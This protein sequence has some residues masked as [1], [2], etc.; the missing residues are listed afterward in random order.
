[1]SAPDPSDLDTE[2][3]SNLDYDLWK[4]I[5]AFA[6][7]HKRLLYPLAFAAVA[8]SIVES[9]YPIATKMAVDI[10]QSDQPI[11][12]LW[13][14]GLFFFGLSIVLSVLVWLFIVCAGSISHHI[15]FDIKRACFKRLQELEFSFYDAQ[16]TGW[17]IS[18]LT[19]DCDRLSRILAWGFLDIVWGLC[20]VGAMAV[21]M[22]LLNA[23]LALIVLSTILPLIVISKFF[24][25]RM[26]VASRQIRKH[27]ARI[28]ASYNEG[29]AGVKTTKTLGRESSN[30]EE[31]QGVSTDMYG[32][33]IRRALLGAV[34]MPLVMAIGA[35]G[36]GLALWYGGSSVI[37]QTLSLGTLIAL[38]SFAGQFFFPINQIAMV[39]AEL[40]GAQAAGERVMSLLATRPNINDS[41]QVEERLA[42]YA[43]P[44]DP[45][46]APDGYDD[47]IERIEFVDIGFSYN[48]QEIILS[49]F[50]LA[51]QRGQTI[52]LVGPSGGGKSTIVSLLSR[53]YEPTRGS[54][55]INGI[56]YRE[57]SLSWLQSQLGIVLQ[58]PHLFN[59]TVREN[60]RYG[61]LE[62]TD[63]ELEEVA[64]WVNAHEFVSKLKNGYDTTIGEGGAR[65]STGERQL[66]SFA[67]ALIADPQIFIMDEA[68]SSI[69]TETERL[70][71][72][73]MHRIFEGRIN[74]VIAHRLSTIRS[75]DRILVIE[76]G[77]IVE[78]GT[79]ETLLSKKG[80]YRDL[81]LT[82]F[83]NERIA[84]ALEPS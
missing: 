64:R 15:S 17:L 9:Q 84:R 28:T 33:S 24:R 25:I 7:G 66:I 83:Q 47:R 52:A 45:A 73:G 30:L 5:F 82:Q 8:L 50:N 37:A 49:D 20:F 4:R 60:I 29:I 43:D 71:Q 19:A 23:K 35:V 26:L 70:I 48:D 11:E 6:L 74:F 65:L 58:T 39:L 36:S 57:R 12:A 40:Q 81:Y 41:T 51:V 31:F 16:P 68:T 38:I 27:N 1:M 56:D 77:T 69:D 54:L 61:R 79:H 55:E 18:R 32:A 3:Q 62:A 14:P 63:E 80:H 76:K 44:S 13:K 21:T 2:Y 67:R 34:Y 22:L 75:A 10:I 42:R 53:F 78:Q 59:G 46:I 72:E